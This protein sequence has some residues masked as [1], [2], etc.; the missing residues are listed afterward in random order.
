MWGLKA[1]RSE[2]LVT[3]EPGVGLSNSMHVIL[4]SLAVL[5]MRLLHIII[6]RELRDRETSTILQFVASACHC[7]KRGS[8]FRLEASM[9]HFKIKYNIIHELIS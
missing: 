5:I 2:N 4:P 3:S 9:P 1:S 7:Q 8:H 6:A